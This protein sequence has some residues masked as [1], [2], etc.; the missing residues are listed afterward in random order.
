MDKHI[1]LNGKFLTDAEQL[2]KKGYYVQSSE[3]L[4]RATAQML[5]AVAIRFR[6]VFSFLSLSTKAIFELLIQNIILSIL[7]GI[8]ILLFVVINILH[9]VNFYSA[10]SWWSDFYNLLNAIAISFIAAYIF[11]ILVGYIPGKKK[12]HIIKNNLRKQYQQLKETIINDFVNITN[13]IGGDI[14]N[15]D[16]TTKLCD[17]K[18]FREYFK[19]NNSKRWYQVLNEIDG[20]KYLLREMLSELAILRDEISFVLNNVEIYDK[21]VFAFFKNLS[22]IIYRL[23]L[24]DFETDDSDDFKSLMSFIWQMFAG[25]SWIEGYA[26]VDVVQSIIDKV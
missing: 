12:R 20:K 2:I 9:F 5:K 25:W 6:C 14:S 1:K 8:I 16:L 19:E 10:R 22:Q 23:E 21:Q 13:K 4:W 26:E 3:K 18:E 11:Y 7:M 15:P 17:I 24:S